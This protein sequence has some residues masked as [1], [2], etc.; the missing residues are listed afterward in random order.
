[1]IHI[2]YKTTNTVN[3]KF[4]I[5][6]HSTDN[7][8]DGYLGS[9]VILTRAV[10]KH[11]KE[12]FVREVIRQFDDEGEAYRFERELIE[13]IGLDPTKCYNACHGGVGFWK[14]MTHTAEAKA[15]ISAA[16]KGRKMPPGFA[17]KMSELM[18]GRALSDTA[19]QKLSLINT[20]RR[21]TEEV[22][23]K[24]SEGGKGRVVSEETKGRISAA[25]LGQPSPRKGVSLTEETKSKMSTARQGCRASDST[26]EKIR[27]ATT[28]ANNAGYG[29]IW[30]TDGENNTR[31]IKGDKIPDGWRQGRTLRPY[32]LKRKD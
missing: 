1:M 14:G 2:V 4:Y 16:N 23:E 11:G 3:G 7:L 9:G 18:K 6:K 25:R 12:Q 22:K 13:S 8:D 19:K 27:E 21:L 26:K 20:G 24:I 30:I 5:G 10:K 32:K 15:K 17:A 31:V 28:G 29:K